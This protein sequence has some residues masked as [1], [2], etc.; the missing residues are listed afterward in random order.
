VGRT[1]HQRRR[2]RR[3]AHL[4]FDQLMNAA[5][6]R[7]GLRGLVPGAHQDL[8]LIGGEHRQLTDALLAI[9]DHGLQQ[10][11]PVPCHACDGW[12]VE[13]VVGVGQ[14]GMQ[15]AG[16]FVSVE[17]QVELGGAALPLHRGQLQAGGRADRGDVGHHRLVVVHHLEQRRMAQAALDVQRFHQAFEGQVLMGLGAQGMLLDGMQQLADAGLPG[18]FGAQHLGVDEETDQPFDF[19][20]VAVGDRHADADVAPGQCSDAAAH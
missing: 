20:P 1:E 7:I 19:G 15:G 13:Q 8:L 11:D 6:A 5:L 14:R 4:V 17:G 3:G 18:Q 9:G 12:R 10:A 2:L 16:L